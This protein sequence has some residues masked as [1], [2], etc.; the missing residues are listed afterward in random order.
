M[1]VDRATPGRSVQVVTI[2]AGPSGQREDAVF[3]IEMLDQPR[4]GQPLGNLLGG[5]M[6]R[7]KIVHQPQTNQVGQ[8]HFDRHGAAIGRTVIAQASAVLGPGCGP[9]D[10]DNRNGRSHKSCTSGGGC[11]PGAI[12]IAT[13]YTDQ[14]QGVDARHQINVDSMRQGIRL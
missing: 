4:F 14:L 3:E 13:Q 6:L 7:F 8:F 1:L 11:G 2:A 10:I 9:V 12:D 5:L